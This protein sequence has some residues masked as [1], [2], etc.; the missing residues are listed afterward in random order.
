MENGIVQ[1]LTILTYNC[2]DKNY[3]DT[4]LNCFGI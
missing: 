4:K 1:N 3:T 2:V